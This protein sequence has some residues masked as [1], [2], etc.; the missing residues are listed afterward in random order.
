MTASELRPASLT[1]GFDFARQLRDPKFRAYLSDIGW[2]DGQHVVV[3]DDNDP[4]PAVLT[5]M[6]ENGTSNPCLIAIPRDGAPHGYALMFAGVQRGL[7]RLKHLRPQ[8]MTLSPESSI[9]MLYDSLTTRCGEYV[10][11]EW[12]R[13]VV[14]ERVAAPA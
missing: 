9:G 11:S 6:I 14:F 10:P 3:V 13:P 7:R 5:R 2:A 8:H 4:V 12:A 1:A